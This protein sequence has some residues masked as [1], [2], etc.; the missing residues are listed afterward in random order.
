MKEHE[1]SSV[2]NPP[3]NEYS[4][5]NL[6]LY[7]ISTE[8]ISITKTYNLTLCFQCFFIVSRK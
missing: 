3:Y 8:L 2:A 1:Q 6:K 4:K 7:Q 5:S